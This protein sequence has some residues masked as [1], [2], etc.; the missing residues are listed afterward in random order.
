MDKRTVF[1]TCLVPT[2][3][4][5]NHR[6]AFNRQK[7]SSLRREHG[8]EGVTVKP[9]PYPTRYIS[10]KPLTI[11]STTMNPVSKD[12]D[13]YTTEGSMSVDLSIRR[14]LNVGNKVST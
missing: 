6:P 4:I 14:T 1:R 9:P 5:D 13:Q 7:R 3:Q 10:Y 2:G 12:F 11:G 8:G